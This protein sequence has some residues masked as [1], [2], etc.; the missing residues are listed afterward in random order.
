MQDIHVQI[1]LMEKQLTHIR[2]E[3]WLN[4]D[5]FFLAMVDFGCRSNNTMVCMVEIC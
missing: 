3:N 5:V 4:Q 2:I 1:L